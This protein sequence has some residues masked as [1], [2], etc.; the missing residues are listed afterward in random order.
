M[1]LPR[2]TVWLQREDYD[3]FKQLAPH[4]PNLPDTFDDWLQQAEKDAAKLESDGRSMNK[5]IVNPKEFA[6][7]CRASGIEANYVT[8]IQFAAFKVHRR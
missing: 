8:L 3:A 4:D 2:I 7:Y 1:A 6:E 5:V